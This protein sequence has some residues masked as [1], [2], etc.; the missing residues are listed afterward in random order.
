MTDFKKFKSKEINGG[1]Q[2]LTFFPNGYG[3]SIVQHD[4]SYGHDYGL[5]EM[6]VLK[7]DKDKWNIT[8]STPIT[9]DVLG[10]LSEDEVN[11]YVKQVIAL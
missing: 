2:Y 6:A 8:Y 9:D 10:S 7:G 1:V 5:W 4:F 3:V 11:E